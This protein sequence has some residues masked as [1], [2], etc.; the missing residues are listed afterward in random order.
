VSTQTVYRLYWDFEKE[1]RWLNEMAAKGLNLSS[2]F[3]GVYRFEQGQPGEWIY[4]IELLPEMPQLPAGREYRKF[5]EDT[6]VQTVAVNGR[7]VYFRRPAADGPFDLFSDLDS[8]ITHYERVRWLT[9]SVTLALVPVTVLGAINTVANWPGISATTPLL[10]VP[11]AILA[12][13]ASLTW[14]FTQRVR[15]LKAQRQLFE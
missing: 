13:L 4:R 1:E 3:M 12:G 5:M 8:R 7:W 15:S 10:L 11:S 14:R 6:G 9:G 2:F